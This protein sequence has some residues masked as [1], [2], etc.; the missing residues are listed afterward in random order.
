M[1]GIPTTPNSSHL[2]SGLPTP[3]GIR[4][5][6]LAPSSI[7][8]VNAAAADNDNNN[9]SDADNSSPLLQAGRLPRASLLSRKSHSSLRAETPPTRITPL[10]QGSPSAASDASPASGSSL[11]RGKSPLPSL[12]TTSRSVATPKRYSE[13]HAR[14]NE[15]R[16]RELE[17]GDLVRMEASE[18][19]G[20]LRHL[21]P[22]D[23][24][25]GFYAGLELTGD[26]LGKGKNDGS[27]QAR[28]ASSMSNRPSS[29]AS[30][31]PDRSGAI[32]P[33]RRRASTISRPPSTTP[34]RVSSRLSVRPPSVTPA[35]TASRPASALATSRPA[36]LC[37]LHL[38]SSKHSQSCRKR[39]SLGGIP[40]PRATKGRASMF[41]RP[42]G[43][44]T[45][46]D[47]SMPPP[48]SPSKESRPERASSVLSFRSNSRLGRDPSDLEVSPVSA[49]KQ[50]A[51][52]TTTDSN[53]EKNRL[54]WEQMDLTPR[55]SAQLASRSQSR[56]RLRL[57]VQELEKQNAELRRDE[58]REKELREKLT[59]MQQQLGKSADEHERYQN[60][61]ESRHRSLQAKLEASE[62]LVAEMKSRIEQES[63]QQARGE[64]KEAFETQLKLKD[65]EID[66]L[67]T[68]INASK[69]STDGPI[70]EIEAERIEV[71]DSMQLLQD[72][73]QEAIRAA[74][75]RVEELQATQ[76][77][78]E[79]VNHLQD[80]LGKY[81]DQISEAA[82]ALDK[83]KEYAQKRR[84]KSHEVETSLKNE[85]KRI[86]IEFERAQRS[87]KEQLVLLE[88]T[89]H[90]LQE[91]QLALE[92]ERAELEG[93]R[94][95]AENFN[96]LKPVTRA[97][98]PLQPWHNCAMTRRSSRR[99][100]QPR[101]PSLA[102]CD[103]GSIKPHHGERI[104]RCR[105]GSPAF[106]ASLRSPVDNLSTQ[107]DAHRLSAASNTSVNSNLKS[108]HR[109]SSNGAYAASDVSAVSSANQMSGLSYLV[110]QLSEENN[111]IK[112]KHKLLESD[113]KARAQDA[114][115]KSRALE[116]TVES[117]RKQL[118]AAINVD[119][120][121]PDTLDLAEKLAN[122]EA[123]LQNSESVVADLRSTLEAT[124][125]E[126]R[127]TA[128]SLQKEVSQLEALGRAADRDSVAS[129]EANLSRW[130]KQGDW[131]Y[132]I[133]ERGG[134]D[135]TKKKKKKKKKKKSSTFAASALNVD[136]RWRNATS[137]LTQQVAAAKAT[138]PMDRSTRS[139]NRAMIAARWAIG[140]KTVLMLPRSSNARGSDSTP[141]LLF[142]VVSV[143]ANTQPPLHCISSSSSCHRRRHVLECGNMFIEKVFF[144][145]S[146]SRVFFTLIGATTGRQ[147]KYLT[148][149]NPHPLSQVSA[150]Q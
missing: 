74:E 105:T 64:T 139:K 24:K 50:D 41:A 136:T 121:A 129:V 36:S 69:T 25:P 78:R 130:R 131:L 65:A 55:K 7:S 11:A 149:R 53:L 94:A 125:M 88:E 146:I 30:D 32:T 13:I 112:T 138:Q 122:S 31:L 6:S 37:V 73:A 49:S 19:V 39:Q 23:F 38:V 92:H 148:K 145:T 63:A 120:A 66:S 58:D 21:G 45:T 83:E 60:E 99:S 137:R 57:Q 84:D 102:G 20:V 2:R 28:P 115:T 144:A 100:S 35:S 93:L 101:I 46:S 118:E 123:Q 77:L 127:E 140:S 12:A 33:S 72:K 59:E 119:A 29:R 128:D 113:L 22:V 68:S 26:S 62:Q 17:I 71:L 141:L 108:N 70:E 67:K 54:L 27:V 44:P 106:D 43:L 124:K 104:G 52:S 80:K 34:S 9:N 150:V 81:E 14:T 1:S 95:D 143:V 8:P 114:E 109:I 135:E 103:C 48:P 96:A 5:T 40:T 134:A 76:A 107:K 98:R 18:L 110:R 132:K 91:S 117:L 126:R 90:A 86:R 56:Q 10:S 51:N 89:R 15:R 133:K 116:L 79:Q 97:L 4:R 75:A 61:A 3:S 85:L 147:G 142:V 87:S 42:G 16:G 82:L 111:E 47:A